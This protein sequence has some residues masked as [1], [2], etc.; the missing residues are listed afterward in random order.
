MA[1]A[2]LQWSLDQTAVA[3]GVSRRTVLRLEQGESLQVRNVAA[4]RRAF[5]AAGV[6]FIDGSADA[7]GVVPPQLLHE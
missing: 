4:I 5:E 2:A 1:R 6:R 3:S 7:S